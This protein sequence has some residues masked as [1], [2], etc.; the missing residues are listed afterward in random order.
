[1]WSQT[2]IIFRTLKFKIFF[3]KVFVRIFV[4]VFLF[5]KVIFTQN[6]FIQPRKFKALNFI[7]RRDSVSDVVSEISFLSQVRNL[8]S[9]SS[10]KWIQTLFSRTFRSGFSF[11]LITQNR[12]IYFEAW[13]LMPYHITGNGF[14]KAGLLHLKFLLKLHW[15]KTI[16]VFSKLQKNKKRNGFLRLIMTKLSTQEKFTPAFAKPML[17]AVFSVRRLNSTCWIQ[18]EKW[19]SSTTIFFTHEIAKIFRI[20][21]TNFGKVFT[22]NLFT[23]LSANL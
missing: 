1:M 3:G 23:P 9:Q 2:R 11:Y 22:Q 7:S 16:F 8:F 6:F 21:F 13:F 14:A 18:S 15:A 12:G 5:Q 20:L 17:C 10:R 19:K 4:S